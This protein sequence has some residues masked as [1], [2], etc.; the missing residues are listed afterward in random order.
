MLTRRNWLRNTAGLLVAAP[1]IVQAET[2][3]KVVPY[4]TDSQLLGLLSN[5]EYNGTFVVVPGD[6]FRF[7]YNKSFVKEYDIVR[8]CSFQSVDE[9]RRCLKLGYLKERSPEC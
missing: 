1:M 3:M 6:V 5:V 9:F 8:L 4:S 2:L 7:V